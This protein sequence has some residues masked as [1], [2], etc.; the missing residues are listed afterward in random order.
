MPSGILVEYKGRKS[1]FWL[2]CG[3][4]DVP[5]V[6]AAHHQVWGLEEVQI[7][8]EP[9]MRAITPDEYAVTFC[10]GWKKVEGKDEMV[11]PE[12]IDAVKLLGG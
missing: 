12:N 4:A 2:P 3:R 5:K 8:G 11:N 6:L 7:D 1:K 9:V 10:T